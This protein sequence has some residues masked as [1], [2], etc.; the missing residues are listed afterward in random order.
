MSTARV[1]N[2]SHPSSATTNIVNDSSGNVAVGN[3]LTVAATGTFNTL[4]LTNPLGVSYGG[5]GLASTPANGALNIGNGTGFTRATLTAGTAISV[6]NGAGSISIANTGVT[7][8]V[9]GTGVSVSG[10]TGAV[11][12]SIGQAVSTAS[13]V[14]FNSLGVGTGGSGTAG[15]IRATNNVTAYYSDDRLKTRKG[16]IQNALAKLESLNGFHY[17]ANETAQ[18]LGY[19]AKPEVGISAQEVRAVLPEIVV[20][21]PIDENYLTIHYERIVPL[22]IEAIKELSAKVAKLEKNK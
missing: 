15:E 11:T 5:T 16:N 13:N 9:A 7:S 17:E 21:A 22:L 18:A 12:I 20:P 2:V 1:I 4:N 14:Q 3:S 19:K 6:S 8:A 10:A